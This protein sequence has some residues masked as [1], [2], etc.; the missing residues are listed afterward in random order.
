MGI[1]SAVCSHY[2]PRGHTP[3]LLCRFREPFLFSQ[4]YFAHCSP[5]VDEVAG[6][7]GGLNTLTIRV[8]YCY[9][10]LIIVYALAARKFVI[11]RP[12]TFD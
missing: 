11:F 2:H 3:V 4:C 9:S 10:S 8:A 5:S 6:L 7:L 12:V 1:Y